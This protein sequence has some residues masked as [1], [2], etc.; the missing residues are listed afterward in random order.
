LPKSLGAIMLICHSEG[1][2]RGIWSLD[3]QS[4]V[5]ISSGLFANWYPIVAT[6]CRINNLGFKWLRSIR[7]RRIGIGRIKSTRSK[8]YLGQRAP[9][10]ST[11]IARRRWDKCGGAMTGTG[12]PTLQQSNPDAT[13]HNTM[14]SS[15][16]T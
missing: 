13:T 5:W 4:T 3:C 16:Q 15:R 8:R 9:P 10:I 12:R 7:T 2:R 11:R 6:R 1:V 14:R